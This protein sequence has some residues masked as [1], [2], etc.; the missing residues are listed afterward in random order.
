MAPDSFETLS[1]H[2]TIGARYDGTFC[3]TIVFVSDYGC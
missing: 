3:P 1:T 2:A